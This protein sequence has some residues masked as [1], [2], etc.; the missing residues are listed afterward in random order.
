VL[1]LLPPSESK[2]PSPEHGQPVD[3][4]SL[5]FPELTPLRARIV[6]ALMETSSRADAFQRLFVR[7]T[8]AADV[9]RNAL[10]DELPTRRALEVY[11][12]PLHEGLDA[13]DLSDAAAEQAERSLVVVSP[14][15]G[16][17]RPSDR[18]PR[19]RCHVCARLVGM[20]RLEPTW[21]TVLPDVLAAA[22]GAS[23][24]IVDLRSPV[25]QAMGMP[26]GLGDRTVTLRVDQGPSGHRLGDVISK[27]VRGQ[28]AGHLLESGTEPQDPDALAHILADQWPVRLEPPERPGR[29]WTMTL[30]VPR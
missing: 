16:A 19:Y 7:P 4:E 24:V 18:I 28:A 2:A 13:A 10:L 21:R 22:A 29:S 27:R 11:T 20:D 15:W 12:G 25:T 26:T 9:A 14:V 1:I 6:D 23:G 17:L 8:V 5:S 3:V 30:T